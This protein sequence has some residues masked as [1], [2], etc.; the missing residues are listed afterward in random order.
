M[1]PVLLG[2]VVC[3][4]SVSGGCEPD[5]PSRPS[6]H[7]VHIVIIGEAKDE[8][9]WPV[10]RS[11]AA[12]LTD[13]LDEV[14]VESVAPETSS[15]RAQLELLKECSDRE[16]SAVCIL[17]LDPESLRAAIDALVRT[18]KPVLT[19][20]RDVEGSARVSYCGPSE[21]DLG[22]AAAEACLATM[23]DPIKTVI[24]LSS[25]AERY[26]RRTRAFKRALKRTPRAELMREVSCEPSAFDAVRVVR[27]ESRMYP[28]VGAWVFLDDWPLRGLEADERLV[29]RRCRV[30]VCDGSPVYF[31][32]LRN[33]EI[34]SL[35]GYDVREAAREVLLAAV[36]AASV[37]EDSPR[38]NEAG[39]VTIVPQF[40]APTEIITRRNVD[41]HAARW[42]EWR[43]H[44]RE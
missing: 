9:T 18:G 40:T 29:P 39:R 43:T 32:N 4:V 2:A 41:A 3:C 28:R 34:Y 11:A 24:L 23:D 37:D 36:R 7:A 19:F 25:K 30:V 20:G 17:P 14:T 26:G 8:P 21:I 12:W 33:G 44:V 13:Y 27:R 22:E 35:I 5:S 31:E 15:P 10:I 42:A 1:L 38:F 6:K 16:V